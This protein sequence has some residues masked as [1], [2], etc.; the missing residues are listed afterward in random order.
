MYQQPAATSQPAAPQNGASGRR[1]GED[2]LNRQVR[3][4]M[5]ILGTCFAL[6]LVIIVALPVMLPYLPSLPFCGA[7]AAQAAGQ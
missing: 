7:G 5:W 1:T 3:H 4:T 2:L 6:G